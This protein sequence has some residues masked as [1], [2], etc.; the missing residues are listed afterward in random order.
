[1]NNTFT[2][3]IR[4]TTCAYP[5]S[6]CRCKA[7]QAERL[8]MFEPEDPGPVVKVQ[9]TRVYSPTTGTWSKPHAPKAAAAPELIATARDVRPLLDEILDATQ[10][11]MAGFTE[12]MP[13]SVQAKRE[14]QKLLPIQAPT[15]KPAKR[16]SLSDLA[17]L[18]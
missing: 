5:M 7:A 11:H 8:A 4:C 2:Q 17:A 18:L 6:R 12:A 1:M 14:T 16:K 9:P 13:A 10:K 3:E 15:V